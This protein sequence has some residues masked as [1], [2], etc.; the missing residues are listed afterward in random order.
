MTRHDTQGLP[1]RPTPR[2]ELDSPNNKVL[3]NTLHGL[4]CVHNNGGRLDG[5][6]LETKTEVIEFELK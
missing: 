3:E 5:D 1:C 2:S 4:P 6:L